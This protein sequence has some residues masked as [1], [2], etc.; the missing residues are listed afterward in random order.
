MQ[1]ALGRRGDYSVRAMLVLAR[2]FG[3]GRRKARQIAKTMDIPERYLP[4]IMAPLVRQHFVLA[5]AGP[6][7]GYELARPPAAITLL[8]VIEAAEGP[9]VRE[10][11]LLQGGPG[12][13]E[14]MCP[15][16]DVWARAYDALGHEL[17]VS[18]F[19]QLAEND[20]LIEHGK[21]QMP[22]E[23]LHPVP[24]EH[25]GEREPREG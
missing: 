25:R 11:C 20:R 17:R 23:P 19:K 5:T 7:G 12:D 9:L 21:F 8:E 2:A 22:T 13:W 10:R 4:Q 14:Q 16:H 6:D 3:D 24:V 18:T 15:I 1:I